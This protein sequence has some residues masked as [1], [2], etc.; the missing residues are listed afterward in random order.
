MIHPVIRRSFVKRSLELGIGA[1]VSAPWLSGCASNDCTPP[2]AWAPSVL[3]PVFYGHQDFDV[4]DG[5]PT[6]VRVFYPSLGGVPLDA[7]IVTCPGRYPLVLFLHGQCSQSPP[8]Y[9]SWFRLPAT[10]A[11][12][13]FVVAVPDLGWTSGQ[14][15]WQANLPQYGLAVDVVDWMHTAWSSRDWLSGSTTLGLVGHSYGALLAGYLAIDIP[16]TTYVSV[17]GGWAEH[18]GVPSTWPIASLQ[19]PS[20]FIYG[21][22]DTYADPTS[23][24]V[25]PTPTHPRTYIVI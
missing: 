20:L 7:P 4:A 5:A 9:Q 18:P 10:L 15:P 1:S 14:T 24:N 12:C 3:A 2:I 25:I 13:G 22:A 6:S 11:R 19:V 23:W 16:T 8:D 17:G 21:T